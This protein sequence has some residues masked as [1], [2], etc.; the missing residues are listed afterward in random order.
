MLPEALKLCHV[1]G[2]APPIRD[3][4][5]LGLLVLEILVVNR[6]EICSVPSLLSVTVPL[7]RTKHLRWRLSNHMLTVIT[8]V[9]TI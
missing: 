2:R 5:S 7:G 3:T 9:R 1:E 4:K 8:R 6:I